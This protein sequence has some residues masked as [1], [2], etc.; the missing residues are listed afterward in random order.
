MGSPGGGSRASVADS[1]A[2]DEV[3]ASEEAPPPLREMRAAAKDLR[4]LADGCARHALAELRVRESGTE[5]GHERKKLP[6]L[7]RRTANDVDAG[8]GGNACDAGQGMAGEC[9]GAS[10]DVGSRVKGRLT[11]A[12]SAARQ[13]CD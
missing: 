12:V 13:L 3:V 6:A 4:D 10:R 9:V 8:C 7:G 1:Q 5:R 2:L 11:R